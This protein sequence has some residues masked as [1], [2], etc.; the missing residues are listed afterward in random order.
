MKTLALLTPLLSFLT[1]PP[2]TGAQVVY[3]MIQLRTP[4]NSCEMLDDQPGLIAVTVHHHFT[5][6]GLATRFRVESGP[7]VTWTYVSETHHFANTI[8]NTQTGVEVCYGACEA[9]N[10]APVIT[11]YYLASGTSGP[12]SQLKVVPH[13]SAETVE[14]ITCD[15]APIRA[16][17][18]G[19]FLNPS[20]LCS[21][22]ETSTMLP[23]TPKYFGCEPLATQASTWGGV[24]ALY[25]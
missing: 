10:H 7:G 14:V 4:T 11:I 19:I 1:V 25:R 23:G 21:P 24:K 6:G 18:R 13:P 5:L 3:D 20:P 17:A 2:T 22:C 15:G 16:W 12:C 8:G 9:P